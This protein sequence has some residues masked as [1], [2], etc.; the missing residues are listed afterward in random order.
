MLNINETTKIDIDIINSQ[1]STPKGNLTI[2]I[3]GEV[4][5]NILIQKAK[6]P[7]GFSMI[8]C[9]RINEIIKGIVIGRINCWVSDSLSTADPIEA[10]NELYSKYPPKK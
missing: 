6:E 10:N 8:G 1:F 7:S 3:T 9:I 5:G 2:I 4:R